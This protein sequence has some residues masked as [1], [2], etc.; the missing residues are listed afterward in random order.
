MTKEELNQL[1]PRASIVC[2]KKDG[3]QY[4]YMGNKTVTKNMKKSA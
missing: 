4:T 1:I 3:V 2:A